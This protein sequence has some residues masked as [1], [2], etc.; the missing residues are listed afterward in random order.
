MLS[1][2]ERKIQLMK[3]NVGQ[4]EIDIVKEVIE[5]G[6][7]VQGPM[8]KEF[9]TLAAKYINVKHAIS[10]TSWTSGAELVFRAMNFKEGDEVI[11]ADFSH[12][13]TALAVITAGGTPVFVDVDLDSRNTTSEIVLEAI[14]D[15]TKC[16]QPVSIFGNPVD[17]DPI[18]DLAK[19][20]ELF[21]VDDAACTLG[22]L[23][24]GK[25]VG[26]L[27]DFTIFSFHPRKVFTC[28]DG[29][30][31]TTN[32]D[33]MSE[34]ILSMKVFGAENGQFRNWGTNQRMSNIHGAVLLGQI[35]RI[36]EIVDARV[37]RARKYDNFLEK[38]DN[39]S[40]PKIGGDNRSNYQTYAIL[41]E[42]EL[43]NVAEI[44]SKIMQ[45]MKNKGVQTQIGTYSISSTPYLDK[46]RKV[47]E[48]NNSKRLASGLLSLP[49]HHELDDEDIQYVVEC[50]EESIR[51]L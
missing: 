13:A 38:M 2:S 8:V 40:V 27:T 7:L 50:L 28:G 35:R 41:L 26:G 16:I 24:K 32:D 9:E 33:E 6:Y 4:D 17:I 29:G 22:S 46:Y 37:S 3:P 21:V 14:T 12:P 23:Y 48:L 51:S 19:R 18:N 49:L 45:S 47:G 30:L 11:C 15:K 44:R 1:M 10:C 39:I 31:I 5:S 34:K 25:P 36:E 42:F 43:E 20:N